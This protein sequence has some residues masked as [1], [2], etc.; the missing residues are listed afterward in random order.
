MQ[1]HMN[2][3]SDEELMALYQSGDDKAFEVLYK[4]HSGRVLSYLQ[5]RSNPQTARDLLQDAFLKLHRSRHQY[6]TQYPFLP[7]LF[8][9]TRNALVDFTRLN[10]TKVAKSST[11]EVELVA[12]A[13]PSLPLTDFEPALVTLSEPQRRTIELRYMQDWSFEKIAAEMQTT[14]LNVRQIISRSL[15]KLRSEF[16]GN[17][18]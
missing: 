18:K 10:E 9:I 11:E 7:W 14:P 12:A 6:S 3:L 17:S 1:V 4:R 2:T 16:G 13:I 15:K 8:T 5:R